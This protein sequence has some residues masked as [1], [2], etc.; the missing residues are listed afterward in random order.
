MIRIV[1][2]GCLLLTGMLTGCGGAPSTSSPGTPPPHGG[3]LIVLPGGKGYVEVVRAAAASGKAP[4]TNEATFYF[5]KDM[6]SPYSPAPRSGILTIGKK[7][8]ALDP[9]GDGLVTPSGPSLFAK[10]DLDGILSVELE[11]KTINIPLGIR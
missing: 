5:L 8:V 3:S 10:G 9:G 4:M 6:A 1:W 11:G 7:K 2:A